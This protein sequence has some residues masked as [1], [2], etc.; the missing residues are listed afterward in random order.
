MARKTAFD[1]KAENVFH[2]QDVNIATGELEQLTRK[3]VNE[4]YRVATSTV[5]GEEA[6]TRWHKRLTE[7]ANEC[8]KTGEEYNWDGGS[9][10]HAD[11][12]KGIADM[13]SGWAERPKA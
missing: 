8:I 1:R 10:Y 12:A 3:F 2:K 13:L 7:I 6:A 9:I 4:V 5:A 11:A